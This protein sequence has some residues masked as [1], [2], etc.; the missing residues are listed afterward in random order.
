MMRWIAALLALATAM[1]EAAP[2]SPPE[3]ALADYV[4]APDASFAWRVH[5]RYRAP[6]ADV[7]ELRLDSQTWRGVLWKHQLYLI[8]P[9][10]ADPDMDHGLVVVGGGRWRDRYETDVETG[11]PSRARLFLEI[12]VELDTV[13]AV[14][15]QVPFQPLLGLSEDELIAHT[16]E[17]Y[18]ETGDAEWPLL[19]PMVKSV[20]RAM[21]AAQ[22]FAADDWDIGLERFTVIGGS[23][24]GWTTWLTGAVDPRAAVLVPIVIDALDFERH[25]PYQT[26]VWGAPSRKLS[27]YTK[28]GLIDA[29]GSE[30]GADLRRIV[31][32][33]SYRDRLR[34]PK[35]VVVATNDA[36]FPLD[37][38][39]LY[40]DELPGPKQVLYLPNDEHDV[41]DFARLIPALNAVH[42]A[43][44]GG[45]PLP[46]LAW[47]LE[48]RD[49]TLALCVRAAPPPA[50]VRAWIAESADADFR[51]AEFTAAPVAAH[52]GVHVFEL[53]WPESGYRAVFA[54]ALFAAQWGGY[55][56]STNVRIADSSGRP[57]TA[58]TAIGGRRGIC[59]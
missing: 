26:T 15:G 39:N 6:Q 56:L 41:E 45:E 25:M 30:R 53:A 23:K 22:A 34:Q 38:M 36:Y 40:W 44:A 5:A 57:P 13:V 19:L 28:H 31:D 32:P 52:D 3:T 37:A 10:G 12:A 48:S 51:D 35:L 46:D 54:E 14:V 17:R 9:D 2:D 20:V 33:Y 7:V 27:P 50:A 43:A 4:T 21:D 11:L 29:L 58:M 49:G 59:P 55:S 1:A 18:L 8:R 16:F 42:R 47:E 24:R